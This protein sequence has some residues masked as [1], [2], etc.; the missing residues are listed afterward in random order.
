VHWARVTAADDAGAYLRTILVRLAASEGRRSWRRR[1]RSTERVPDVAA[2]VPGCAEDR[3]DLAR[4]LATLSAKQ[5]AV[6]VLRFVEDRSVPEVAA[7]LGV[8]V[9]TVKR[10]THDALRRLR[11]QLDAPARTP[12]AQTA[13]EVRRG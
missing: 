9:G 3:V 12:N 1:E 6:V 10:Q 5:R 4:C 8:G 2:S 13:R 11:D 7:I